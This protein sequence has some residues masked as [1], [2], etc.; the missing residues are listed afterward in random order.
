V[1][2]PATLLPVAVEAVDA[3]SAMV[4]DQAVTDVAAKG[5]RDMASNVDL[6][7]EDGVRTFLQRETPEV[8]FVGEERGAVGNMDLHW[9]LDPIDGT[10]NFLHTIPLCAVSLALVAGQ[11]PVLG[12]IQLPYLGTVFTA[13]AGHGAYADG[14]AIRTRQTD[15]LNDAIVAIGD[16]AVGEDADDKN[17]LR[18]ALTNELAANVLRV[19][20]LGSAAIDLAWVAE[21]RLDAALQLSNHPWDNAAGIVLVREAGGIVLGQHGEEHTPES[22]ATIAVAPPLLDQLGALLRHVFTDIPA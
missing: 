6:A 20:M 16:Y 5:D 8:G 4:R 21:G 12:V 17:R 18:F 10:A 15:R 13:A 2:D 19:R 14:H 22:T 1:I 9:T 3:A 7:V 11:R